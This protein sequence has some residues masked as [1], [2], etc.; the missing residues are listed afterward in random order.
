MPITCL[1]FLLDRVRT[2]L[3]GSGNR[4]RHTMNGFVIGVGSYVPALTADALAVGRDLGKVKV[5]M[6]DTACKVPS[7]VEYIEK[8]VGMGRCGQKRKQVRC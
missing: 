3:H 6:G 4:T 2:A 1:A 7:A 8:N 5:D